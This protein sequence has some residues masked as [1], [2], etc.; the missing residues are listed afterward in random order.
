MVS[1][2]ASASTLSSVVDGDAATVRGFVRHGLDGLD[3]ANP[4]PAVTQRIG[5]DLE[6]LLAKGG[7]VRAELRHPNGQVLASSDPAAVG[8]TR[9][10]DEGF[11][12]AVG[13][14]PSV[15]IVDAA[16]AGT[17]PAAPPPHRSP[18]E[19]PP[20][21]REPAPPRGGGG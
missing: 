14:S 12:A 18:R 6:T 5:E 4:D 7:I 20:P 15:A 9:Q 1:A 11:D 17:G 21:R 16:A 3:L 2:Y 10:G 19:P 8:A 13:G